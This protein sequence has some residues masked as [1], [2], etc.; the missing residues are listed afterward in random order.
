MQAASHLRSTIFYPRLFAYLLAVLML[1]QL[2]ADE[3]LGDAPLRLHITIAG[4]MSYP[5]ILDWLQRRF[6]RSVLHIRMA[7]LLD[8]LLV[9]M[10][11]HLVD[12][13][14]EAATVLAALLG[15]SVVIVGGVWL[16]LLVLP[17]VVVGILLGAS[18][19]PF[20]LVGDTSF[21]FLS[22]FALVAYVLFVAYLVFEETRRLNLQ[23]RQEV[24][25][26]THV[27]ELRRLLTSFLPSQLHSRNEHRPPRRQRLTVMFAD[28]QGFTT[29]MDRCDET[30]VAQ[31]LGSYFGRVTEI[32][33]RYGGTVDK[34]MGDG[35]M[36]FFGDPMSRGAAKDAF[37]CIVMALEIQEAFTALSARWQDQNLTGP[38]HLRTGIHTGYCLVGDF[39]SERRKHYTAIGS[40][41][42]RASRLEGHADPDQILVSEATWQLVRTAAQA[43]PRGEVSLRGLR[44]TTRVFSIESV[45]V[46]ELPGFSLTPQAQL[47][48]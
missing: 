3:L 44:E 30:L 47:L 21:Y 13:N 42:N 37:T 31:M 26:R 41:V 23:Q 9:G 38:L 36:I 32:A 15:I 10:L 2:Q 11:M 7:M 45:N 27:E 4:L 12:L 14:L 16:L 18:L 34:F 29:L 48:G 20:R 5:L 46:E 40:T 1:T 22:F 39:G 35:V 33:E 28:I 25:L 19:F 6:S 24:S 17:L 43:T 8:G